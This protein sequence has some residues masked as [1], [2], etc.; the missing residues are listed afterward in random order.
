[1]IGFYS[2]NTHLSRYLGTIKG[3]IT[4]LKFNDILALTFQRLGNSKN[5]KSRFSFECLGKFT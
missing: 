5:S 1:L 3:A 2:L 4:N